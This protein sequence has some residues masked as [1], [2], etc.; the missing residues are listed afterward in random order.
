M[1]LVRR[2]YKITSK[3]HPHW[4]ETGDFRGQRVGVTGQMIL[5]L[6]NCPHGTARVAVMSDEIEEVDI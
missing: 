3:R 2:R 4:N 6:V 1:T 5:H